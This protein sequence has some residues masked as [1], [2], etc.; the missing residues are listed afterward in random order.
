MTNHLR[1]ATWNVNSVRKRLDGLRELVAALAPDILCLQEL[2]ANDDALPWDALSSLGLP[3]AAWRAMKGYNGVMILSRWPI[4]EGETPRF[5]GRDDA[6]VVD[7]IVDAPGYD[8]GLAVDSVYVP[9]GGDVPDAAANP[10]FDHKLGFLADMAAW[11]A[12]IDQNRPRVLV[13]DLNVAPLDCDVWSHKQ[14]LNVVSHTPVETDAFARAQ[15]AGGFVDATR[16]T[17]PAPTRLFSWW[18][19]RA[20]DWAKSDRGRR[21]D[22]I[23]LSPGCADRLMRSEV[24]KEVRGWPEPSDHAPVWA[25]LR[26]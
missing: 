12:G 20:R 26:R 24:L 5:G 2:K 25:D 11:A 1:V 14:L 9:A 21:L 22:H 8:G 19:Y 13:G 16:K 6:R 15:A 7:A 23:W 3:H 17:T 10:K 4:A 18:S